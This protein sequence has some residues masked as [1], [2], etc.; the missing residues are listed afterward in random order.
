MSIPSTSFR[1][2]CAR[3]RR[4]GPTGD[5]YIFIEVA[6]HPIFKRDGINLFCRVPVRMTE[7]ALGGDIDLFGDLPQDRPVSFVKGAIDGLLDHATAVWSADGPVE[8]DERW[9]RRLLEANDRMAAEG[10][11]LTDF[12]SAA[13][14]CTPSRAALLTGC[15]PPRVSLPGVLWRRRLRPAMQWWLGH[16]RKRPPSGDLS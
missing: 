8:L 11:R 6:E 4:G 15:Y 9:R 7:A 16:T 10:M 1:P 14:V 5:L 13:P 2:T 12:Y 3:R